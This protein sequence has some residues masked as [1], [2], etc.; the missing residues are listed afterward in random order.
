MNIDNYTKAFLQLLPSG[1][2]WPRDAN[3]ALAKMVS[4]L[5]AELQRVDDRGADLLAESITAT[6]SDTLASWEADLGL[7]EGRNP[8]EDTGQ[9]LAAVQQKYRIYGSQSRAFFQ[10]LVEA[11]GITAEIREYKEST[12]GSDFGG[13]YIGRDWAFVVE[14]IVADE[15]TDDQISVLDFTIQTYLHAHKIAIVRKTLNIPYALTDD[16]AFLADGGYYLISTP[17]E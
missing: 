7:P 2:V 1:A 10:A 9:R 16:G 15:T 12:F 11:F 6:I 5:A 4:G 3:A 8:P 13:F 14:F 17:E